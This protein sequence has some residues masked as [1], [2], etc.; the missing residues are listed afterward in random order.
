MLQALYNPNYGMHRKAITQDF[1]LFIMTR[2]TKLEGHYVFAFFGGGVKKNMVQ[3]H[4]LGGFEYVFGVFWRFRLL[5]VRPVD[6]LCFVQR[7]C[8]RVL[9][10]GI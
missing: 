6:G 3:K 10:F 5:S 1:A 2:S 4:V 7:T 8:R 9:R